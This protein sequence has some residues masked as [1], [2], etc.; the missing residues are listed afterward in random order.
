MLIYPLSSGNEHPVRMVGAS[1][2]PPVEAPT[3]PLAVSLLHGYHSEIRAPR[4]R[5]G[6]VRAEQGTAARRLPHHAPVA[7]TGRQ[8]DP[9][10]AA[11]QDLFP[12]L[13]RRTRGRPHGGGDAAPARV[14][15]VLP[16]LSRPRAVPPARGNSRRDAVLRG[17]RGEGS[18]L[19]W[20]ADAQ[21]LGKE[22]PE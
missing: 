1:T 10:Q 22:G 9:A 16:V 20:T 18:E 12:D 19:R 7:S 2:R 14:R 4:R 17:G 21:P 11:K 6:V 3:N 15:L 8:G 13:G 5:D